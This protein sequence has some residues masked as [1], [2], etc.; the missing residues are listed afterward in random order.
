VALPPD[1]RLHHGA[2]LCQQNFVLFNRVLSNEI[3]GVSLRR[4]MGLR[5]CPLSVGA[6]RSDARSSPRND[7]PF[8][9][10]A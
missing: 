3:G 7:E 10:V 2:E 4:H 1:S 9:F 5:M 6:R 8:G